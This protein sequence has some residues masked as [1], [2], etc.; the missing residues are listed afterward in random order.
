[1]IIVEKLLEKYEASPYANNERGETA[2]HIACRKMSDLRYYLTKK[3][4]ELLF[5]VNVEGVQ[6]LHIACEKNDSNFFT[7]I[8]QS[9]LEDINDVEDSSKNNHLDPQLSLGLPHHSLSQQF[10]SQVSEPSVSFISKPFSLKHIHH[11]LHVGSE[12]N[13]QYLE[14]QTISPT[15]TNEEVVSSQTLI[16]GH[17]DHCINTCQQPLTVPFELNILESSQDDNDSI[18][19]SPSV[20]SST[21]SASYASNGT[22]SRPNSGTSRIKVEESFLFSTGTLLESTSSVLKQAC[23]NY[24]DSPLTLQNL[25]SLH[26][27]LF[28]VDIYGSSVL[29]IASKHGFA[30][31]L[32][33]ILQVA[34]VLEH[35][36]DGADL[37]ILTRCDASITPIEEAIYSH[38]PVCLKLLLDFASLTPIIKSILNDSTLL[39]KAVARGDKKSVE[40]LI[41]FG[42]FKGL[43]PAIHEAVNSN[44]PVMLQMLMFYYTQVTCLLKGTC[45]KRNK[46][47]CMEKASVMWE[48]LDLIEIDPVWFKDAKVAVTSVSHLLKG[49]KYFHP[50]QENRSMFVQLGNDCTEYFRVHIWQPQ[51]LPKVWKP[52]FITDLN[53]SGNQLQS[54]PPE[55]FQI[56]SLTALDL[57][58][59]KLCGLPSSLD[60]QNPLY[61]CRRLTRLQISSNSLQT[62]PEDLFFAFGDSLEELHANDNQI[63]TLP[64]GLWIC[65]NLHTLALAQNKLKQLH[66]FSN[67]QYF[68]DEEFSRLL[69]DSIKFER[70]I[71]IKTGK[72]DD[73]EFMNILNYVTRLN[74]FYQTVKALL[75]SVIDE[76]GN[77]HTSLLQHVIDIH[78]LR[79]KLNSDRRSTSLH[80]F[81]VSLP[82]DEN[83]KLKSLDLSHNN[84]TSFPWD[85]ACIAPNLEKLDFRN[86]QIKA[87]HTIKNLPSCIESVI[88]SDN[89]ITSVSNVHPVYPC[90]SPVK[91]LSGYLADPT[92][93]GYCKHTEHCILHKVSNINLTNN[94]V[95]EFP[96]VQKPV[97]SSKP[98]ERKGSLDS[99]PYQSLYPS[100]AVL[101]LDHNNLQ[102]VPEGVQYLTQLS[103][104]SLSHNASISRLPPEMGIMNPQTLLIIKLEGVYPKNVNQRLLERPGARG[105]LTYLK[106]LHHQ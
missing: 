7:W 89:N 63:D 4:P 81:D 98:L 29:H 19:L 74:I 11:D 73:E 102:A 101:S 14:G 84:F 24:G 15:C 44:K 61:T 47:I 48:Q 49:R 69:I 55:L 88:L 78:W 5:A 1:M 26:M 17:G 71:P 100:L 93:I 83:C 59:N 106:M 35:N 25:L 105:I 64:P 87:I 40:V 80:Y 28:A 72:I 9:V 66:Y 54:I 94:N 58:H 91:L 86:N 10:V 27:R 45:V 75:P 22:F 99:N 51:A 96:C 57:S 2:L 33:L 6:P 16:N 36:P 23:S 67:K 103:S 60:F 79:S 32:H 20:Y 50:I 62:L 76:D 37:N 34:K 68:Y 38:Q 92:L 70:N 39:F 41:E 3:T 104:L 43:K 8:F 46:E 82:L 21:L 42:I 97:E 85:L 90:G 18:P 12:N 13:S 95:V 53:L 56:E 31:L 52:F 77:E 30:D 65:P